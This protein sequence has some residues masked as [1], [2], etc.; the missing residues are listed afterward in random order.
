[1]NVDELSPGKKEAWMT[2]SNYNAVL[3]NKLCCHE[4]EP[5]VYNIYVQRS[6]VHVQELLSSKTKVGQH[7]S[8]RFTKCMFVE[9][10]LQRLECF[11][12]LNIATKM[13]TS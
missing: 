4:Q 7:H 3:M 5:R 13:V 10:P 9:A 1:M 11:S 12:M 2:C 6:I 8:T